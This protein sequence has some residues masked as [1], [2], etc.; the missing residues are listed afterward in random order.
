MYLLYSRIVPFGAKEKTLDFF[1]G[2]CYYK[3]MMNKNFCK[4]CSDKIDINK[5][6]HAIYCSKKCLKAEEA[7]RYY[8]KGTKSGSFVYREL[9][10]EF[11]G[12]K[13]SKCQSENELQ[14]DHIIPFDKEGKNLISNVQ[15]LCKSCHHKKT[16]KEMG[17][18]TNKR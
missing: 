10:A 17:N 15:I 8:R 6:K 13:C 9:V 18:R 1:R 3:Y 11:L 7:R 4:R 12:R 16:M 2:L 14:I 5:R